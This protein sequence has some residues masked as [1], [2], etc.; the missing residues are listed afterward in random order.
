MVNE[1]ASEPRAGIVTGVF[2][3]ETLNPEVVAL[4]ELIVQERMRLLLLTVSVSCS[5]PPPPVW[6]PVNVFPFT[7][8]S[9]FPRA[10]FRN[11]EGP[12]TSGRV[13]TT[14]VQAVFGNFALRQAF[15]FVS[16]IGY[17]VVYGWYVLSRCYGTHLFPGTGF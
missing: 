12:F 16:L 4:T 3:P 14:K 9:W 1:R 15:T 7:P 10:W 13:P 2:A 8:G 5:A 11:V 6:Y 17:F